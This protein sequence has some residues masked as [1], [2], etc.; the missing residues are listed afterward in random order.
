MQGEHYVTGQSQWGVFGTPTHS[1]FSMPDPP[2]RPHGRRTL[3]IIC[4]EPDDDDDDN[5]ERHLFSG[6]VRLIRRT[7]DEA[8]AI[9]QEKERQWAFPPNFWP[10]MEQDSDSSS[11]SSSSSSD[12]TATH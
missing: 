12:S 10:D 3:R 1:L 4:P 8:E 5:D 11:S 6:N 2:V 7:T 9:R